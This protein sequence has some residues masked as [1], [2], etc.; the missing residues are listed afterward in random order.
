MKE[1]FIIRHGE[2]ELNRLGIVQGSGV[3][4]GLNETGQRQARAFFEHYDHIPFQAVLTSALRRTHETVAPF[5]NRGIQWEQFAEI[6]EI[7]WGSHE[8]KH[9]TPE[10]RE[11]Y[12]QVVE[13]W[14]RG[15]FSA[16]M[17][18]GESAAELARRISRFVD[19]L[20]QRPE[21]KL[22]VCGHGRAMRCMM[23]LL[24]ERPLSQMDSFHH[25]NTGLYRVHYIDEGFQFQ[26]QND[27]QHLEKLQGQ[28][29]LL[30]K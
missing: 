6:N 29:D 27:I 11:E 21:D 12:R 16:R 30:S 10:M 3:D 28:P 26:L 14:R 22:L 4:A 15:D 17:D 9:S 5:V 8:G 25:H 1:I 2:T 7:G 18:D 13:A 19:H 24:S 20:R 23:C